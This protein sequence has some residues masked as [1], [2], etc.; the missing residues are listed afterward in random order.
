MRVIPR[1]LVHMAKKIVPR[2]EKRALGHRKNLYDE[3]SW[4]VFRIMAEFVDG[5][6]FLSEV[7]PAV[8]VF[9]SARTRPADCESP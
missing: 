7:E 9:G 6:E 4:R 8:T 3:D 2:E 1:K 5:F